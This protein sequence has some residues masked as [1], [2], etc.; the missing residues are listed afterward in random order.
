MITLFKKTIVNR[1][2]SSYE[3]I[4]INEMFCSHRVSGGQRP[5]CHSICSKHAG[6]LI[7]DC[8]W[9]SRFLSGLL[10]TY[11]IFGCNKPLIYAP[12]MCEYCEGCNLLR[13]TL[14]PGW[15]SRYSDSLRPGRSG[16]RIP[17]EARLPSHPQSPTQYVPGHSRG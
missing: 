4:D 6:G 9:F 7:V 15:L 12:T 17:V 5:R 16:D 10:R 13:Y 8:L 2:E 1:T 11:K 3:T 14:A